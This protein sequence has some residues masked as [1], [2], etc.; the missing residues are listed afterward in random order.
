MLK[1]RSKKL[2]KHTHSCRKCNRTW[3]CKEL[4]YCSD[5][6]GSVLDECITCCVE[7]DEFKQELKKSHEQIALEMSYEKIWLL[8]VFDKHSDKHTNDH[9]FRKK[10]QA[11]N[12][13]EVHYDP[14]RYRREINHADVR[15]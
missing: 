9:V 5:P 3:D 8:S 7:S 6:P 2:D 1:Y 15:L 10:Q 12:Y 4:T 14:L 13:F 11:V